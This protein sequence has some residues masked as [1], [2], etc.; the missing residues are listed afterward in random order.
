[1]F[2]NQSVSAHSWRNPYRTPGGISCQRVAATHKKDVR[3]SRNKPLRQSKSP[4][5]MVVVG[6][7]VTSRRK[8]QLEEDGTT[9]VAAAT[10]I[11]VV[12]VLE[13]RGQGSKDQERLHSS[14][15]CCFV[16][17]VVLVV[18]V[19]VVVAVLILIEAS[20]FLLPLHRDNGRDSDSSLLSG[21]G[22]VTAVDEYN[23]CMMRPVDVWVWSQV[24]MVSSTPYEVRT[25]SSMMDGAR[26]CNGSKESSIASI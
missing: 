3:V 16:V 1:M 15:P 25:V 12:A 11:A 2:L 24:G 22:G 4:F 9:D 7:V 13:G 8:R 18:V 5:S 21:G 6:S 19:A 17:V 14:C 20:L 26:G 23:R 10:A